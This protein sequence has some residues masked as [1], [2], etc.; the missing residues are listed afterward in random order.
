MRNLEPTIG[1]IGV[2][3]AMIM[4]CVFLVV[5]VRGCTAEKEIATKDR[6]EAFCKVVGNPHDLTLDEW[7]RAP[8]GWTDGTC[9]DHS[10]GREKP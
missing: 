5:S 4:V 2:I 10:E 9:H 8:S 1:Q 7:R 6:Y 3:A